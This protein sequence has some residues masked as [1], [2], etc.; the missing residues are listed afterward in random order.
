MDFEIVLEGCKVGEKKAQGLLYKLCYNNVFFT[1]KKYVK[2]QQQSEDLTQDILLKI[3]NKINKFS[4][5]NKP[6][7][8]Y[9]VKSVARNSTIDFI[10]NNKV[11]IEYGESHHNDETYDMFD[12]L[13]GNTD[14]KTIEDILLAISKLSPKYKIVFELYYLSN[15]T[16][17]EISN[18]LNISIGTSKSNLF[19]AKQ[20]LVKYLNK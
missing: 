11:T 7:L 15:Y 2:C 20:N 6:Q 14:K 3:I 1:C 16:H 10:R 9:W 13:F 18:E 4:G 8:D 19:K 5:V 17:E 12:D